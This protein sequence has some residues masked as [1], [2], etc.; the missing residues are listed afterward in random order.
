[1]AVV[2]LYGTVFSFCFYQAGVSIVGSIT[3]SILSSVEPV[4]SMVISVLFLNVALT[5]LDFAGFLLILASIPII[6]LGDKNH[7]KKNGPCGCAWSGLFCSFQLDSIF[8][9]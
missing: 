9:E 1:M 4:A 8:T 7:K 3:G 6:A 2:I 5:A